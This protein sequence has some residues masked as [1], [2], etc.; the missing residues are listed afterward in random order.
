M[1]DPSV[2][3]QHM[4]AAGR[5]DFRR[6]DLGAHAAARQRRAAAAGHCLDRCVD[7]RNHRNKLG[8]GVFR[9]RRGVKPRH[10]GEQNQEIRA[11]HGRDAGG[12]AIVVAVA[13]FACRDRIVLVD[14][15]H[16][17]EIEEAANRRPRVQIAMALL[18]IAERDQN[19]P[20]DDLSIREHFR[21][22]SRQG[23][24]AHGGGGLAVFEFQVASGEPQH[25][26]PERD[27][28]GRNDEEISALRVQ[29]RDVLCK[30]VEP[31][32]LDAAL[33]AIDQQGR[34]GLD[35]DAAEGFE[36]R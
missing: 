27:R 28:A 4:G 15:R 33:V 18:G 14:D 17:A 34:A 12:Q 1:L 7:A 3:D 32:P 23:D 16:G 25:G 22:D 9:R 10:I 30:R 11:R 26:P 21:P 35:H 24:L 36:A 8:L 5:R 20:G 6:L 29:I 31:A 13:Y 2:G 19:L